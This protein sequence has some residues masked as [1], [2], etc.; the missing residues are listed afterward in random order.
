MGPPFGVTIGE[1]AGSCSGRGTRPIKRG[2]LRRLLWARVG[3]P[4]C[5]HCGKEIQQQT[6]DQI[7]DQ[8][9]TLPEAT[10][11]QVLSPSIWPRNIRA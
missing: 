11:I 1:F 8:V 3:T 10:R 5:P 7:I 6:I 4:H 2:K 9:L